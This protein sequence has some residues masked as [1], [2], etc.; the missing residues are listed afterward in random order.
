MAELGDGLG[1]HGVDVCDAA[2]VAL[3]EEGSVRADLRGDGL[4]G[5][6]VAGVVDCDVGAEMGEEEGGGGADAFTASGDEGGLAGEGSG[7]FYCWVVDG[8]GIPDEKVLKLRT[9]V[10]RFGDW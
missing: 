2:G 10:F 8:F 3:D 6:G 1:D 4:G 9:G 7:H 5:G